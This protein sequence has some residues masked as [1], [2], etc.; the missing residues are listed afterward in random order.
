MRNHINN[1]NPY[2]IIEIWYCAQISWHIHCF[3]LCC[4]QWSNSCILLTLRSFIP[5]ISHNTSLNLVSF[6]V[7]MITNHHQTR[8]VKRNTLNATN[9]R[10]EVETMLQSFISQG[11]DR[12]HSTWLKKSFQAL[13][14]L[15]FLRQLLIFHNKISSF[16]S[17]F[18]AMHFPKMFG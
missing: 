15:Y 1:V 5:F 2:N 11:K 6:G 9:D 17:S 18:N 12:S 7:Q 14:A 10:N 16:P 4:W 13:S 3:K 8:F